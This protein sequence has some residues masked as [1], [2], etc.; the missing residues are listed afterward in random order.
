MIKRSALWLSVLVLMLF[1]Q[2]GIVQNS[3]AAVYVPPASARKIYNFNPGWKF[4]RQNV[5]GAQKPDFNDATWVNVSTPHTFNDVDSYDHIISHSGGDRHAWT[6]TVWYR[7]HF[8]LPQQDAGDQIVLEFEGIRQAAKFWVNGHAVGLYQNGVTACG[9][10]VTH[11]VT[12]GSTDNVIAVKVDNRLNYKQVATGVEYE[13]E[14]RAFNP[15]YGGLHSDVRLI[16]TGDIYQTLPFYDTLKTT[17]IYIY[18]SHFSFR[19][20]TCLVHVHS[21][22]RNATATRQTITLSAV[23]V[24]AA[25]KV[26]ATF[27]GG[28]ATL[29]AHG[30]STLAAQGQLT[31]AHFWDVQNPYLYNV[32]CI[33]TVGGKVVD[34]QKITTGFRQARFK[35]GAGTGGVYLN[36]KFIY[37][38]GYAQRAVDD[39]AGLGEAY[40][41]WMHDYNAA[42]IRSTHANYIRWMHISPQPVDVRACDRFGIIEICPAGDKEYDP[43]LRRGLPHR[44]AV[45]QWQQRVAVMRDSI[46]LYR[47]DPSILFWEA[48]N[49]VLTPAHMRQMVSLR[50]K[51]DPHG[52]RAMGYRGNS[53]NAANQALTHIAE[54]YGVM[55]G[56]DPRTDKVTKPG[57]MFRAYSVGRRNRAPLIECEDFRDEAARRFWDN[58]SPPFFGF[59]PGP[60]DTYHW[61]SETFCLAAAVRYHDY[62]INRISNTNPKHSKWSGYASIYWSDCNADGR[63]DSSEVCRVSGKVDAVRLPKQAYYVYRVMQDPHPAIHIIGHWTYPAGTVK[64]IYVAANHCRTVALFINGKLIGKANHPCNFIDTFHHRDDNWGNTGY[65]Y[66]FPHV[67][68]APG[69]ILAQGIIHGKVVV[70]NSIHTAGA[71]ARLKLTVFTG[72]NG[73]QADGSDVA[74]IDFQVVDARGQRCPTVYQRVNFRLTGPAVWRGGYDSGVVNSVDKLHLIAECGVNRVA[75]RSTAQPGII[76]LTASCPGLQPAVI[77]IQSHAVRIINGLERQMPQRLPRA[78]ARALVQ[79]TLNQ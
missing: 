37:L 16:V 75:I 71:P 31:D 33:L 39:W 27:H 49:S 77:H 9:L 70:H 2:F 58:S 12:F 41:D 28:T 69:T 44:V 76:T 4:I 24:D 32:Y 18:P 67:T 29:P 65:I 45:A 14:S 66:A 64:T 78:A 13:W 3:P 35:G 38:T 61:N 17:G 25:G 40:P 34:V 56:Q 8:K 68:F 54:Y 43:A 63:Q 55:I 50:K 20:K 52:Y 26:C 48:G 7:K 21:Q 53:D 10:N 36:G 42:L 19:N 79:K 59:K 62:Y 11:F 47:N 57:Q 22:V 30:T 5:P 15:D 73:L 6:G 23:V 46:I 60:H 1:A 74:F 51:W 72:P